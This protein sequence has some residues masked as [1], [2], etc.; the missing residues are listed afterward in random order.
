M[1]ENQKILDRITN[2]QQTVITRGE[3]R[4]RK[5]ELNKL[6]HMLGG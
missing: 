3:I 4:K 5:S 6:H 1:E 2:A